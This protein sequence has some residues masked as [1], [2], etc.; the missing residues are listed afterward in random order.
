L[1]LR[2]ESLIWR[3][4]DL[5][6]H[7]TGLRGL[8]GIVESGK[9]WATDIRFLNDTGEATYARRAIAKHIQAYRDTNGAAGDLANRVLASWTGWPWSERYFVAFLQEG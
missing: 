7:Y 4:D 9:I 5:I 8:I 1:H 6:Y 3:L 2:S